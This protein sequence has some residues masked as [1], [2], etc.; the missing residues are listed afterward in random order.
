MFSSTDYHSGLPG[1]FL[2]LSDGPF[3]A[4]EP[5]LDSDLTVHECHIYAGRSLT[6]ISVQPFAFL[7]TP[8]IV[9]ML[10]M[11][12][13]EFWEPVLSIIDEDVRGGA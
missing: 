11:G 5:F 3:D 13:P 4:E 10:A 9:M 12:S 8:D 1:G 7:L 2:Y 6:N